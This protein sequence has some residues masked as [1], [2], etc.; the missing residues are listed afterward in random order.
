M[1]EMLPIVPPVILANGSDQLIFSKVNDENPIKI[2]RLMIE[3]ESITI[4]QSVAID[5]A[6]CH[7]LKCKIGER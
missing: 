6:S 2:T 1:P 3:L 5:F 7:L 4:E